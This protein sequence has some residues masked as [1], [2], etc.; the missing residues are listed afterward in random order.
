MTFDDQCDRTRQTFQHWLSDSSGDQTTINFVTTII[1]TIII[2]SFV[3]VTII[4]TF[5]RR[6]LNSQKMRFQKLGVL[7]VG[8]PDEMT[9]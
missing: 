3:I 9:R 4:I 8:I 5:I 6:A 1:T 7:G 2:T